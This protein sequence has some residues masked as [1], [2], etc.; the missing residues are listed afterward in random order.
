MD[1]S[2]KLDTS[3]MVGSANEATAALVRLRKAIDDADAAAKKLG[4]GAAGVPEKASGP[5]PKKDPTK[6]PAAD[7]SA[8]KD[9]EKEKAARAK[10]AKETA[11]IQ[12]AF[13]LGTRKKQEEAAKDA[14]KAQDERGK[15]TLDALS[16]SGSLGAKVSGTAGL[17]R[18]LAGAGPVG[19]ALAAG[20][21][22]VVSFVAAADGLID[23]AS[24]ATGV[25]S[26][27]ELTN[28][29]L[30]PRGLAGIQVAQA[31]TNL[32]FRRMF[33]GV[34]PG[35]LLR[36]TERFSR[37]FTDQTVTGRALG[38]ILSRAYGGA[39]AAIER[40]EPIAT[41]AMQGLVLGALKVEGAW[42][43]FRIATFDIVQPILDAV[44]GVDAL[45]VA[46]D[47][48][49]APF[50]EIALAIK[51]IEKG[52]K[53]F[54]ALKDAGLTSGITD[55]VLPESIG[56]ALNLYNA[57]GGDK[58]KGDG[59]T[60]GTAAGEGIIAGLDAQEGAIFNAGTRAALAAI[61]G[62]KAGAEV[63]SP[64]RKM[65]REVGRQMGAG[66]ALG[67]E[68]EAPRIQ[69][70]AATSLVPDTGSLPTWIG[71][72]GGGGTITGP[73]LVI[74][75]LVVQGGEEMREQIMDA[76]DAVAARTGENLGMTVP[77]RS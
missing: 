30:G 65:R 13:I 47:I 40:L 33:M 50:N 41:G 36:A 62:A 67:M 75:S 24:K 21:A 9:A 27:G 18:T 51:V 61:K 49:V 72:G 32:G 35:P 59:A 76:L 39:F 25:G 73:L 20:A 5:K 1:W 7:K 31:R 45:G 64:S 46:A 6:P 43:D 11:D 37:N 69:R 63:K 38:D 16:R 60:V 34:D 55:L 42:L 57:L 3:S 14:G 26:F 52:V 48:A 54:G 17:L 10:A 2:A 71:G 29:A 22:G 4:G 8:E 66:V 70:A 15:A 44:G 56:S 68:D 77:A 58:A 23:L 12:R 74:Q 53:A 28:I 19:A